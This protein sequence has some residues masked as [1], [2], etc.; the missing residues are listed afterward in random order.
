MKK[1]Q[2]KTESKRILDLMINSIYTN[3]EIFLRE[4]ISNSSDAMDKLY[5]IVSAEGGKGI[6]RGDF[7][8]V[9]EIDKDSR[10]LIISDNGIGMTREELENNLGTIARSGTMDFRNSNKAELEQTGDK[11]DISDEDEVVDIE[12]DSYRD[13]DIIGQFGVGFYSAFMVSKHISVVSRA[14]GSEEAY[15]WESSGA[16]GYTIDEDIRY[17]HGTTI[18]LILKD[19]TADEDFSRFLEQYTIRTIVKKYSD[20]IRYPIKMEVIKSRQ[21]DESED[22]NPEYEDYTE[23]DTLNSMV[24]LWRRNKNELEDDDYQQFYTDKFHDYEAPLAYSH[25]NA[26]GL[27]SFSGIIYIPAH[28]PYNYYSKE[29]EKGLQLYANGVLIMD[30]CADLLPD[31]FSFVRGLIDSPDLSLNISREILQQSSQL[32]LIAKNL[33]RRI[34][35]ELLSLQENDR[36]KYEE[37]FKDFGLQLKFGIYNSFGMDTEKLQDLLLYHS[38]KEDKLITLAEYI[39]SMPENQNAIYY[40]CG[41]SVSRIRQLPQAELVLDNGFDILALTDDV[42]EFAIKMIREYKEKEI[43]S[44]SDSDIDLKTDIEKEVTKEQA[45]IHKK[46]FASLKDALGDKVKE[47]RLSN[48]LKS[49]PVCI[50]SDGPLSLEMEKVLNSMPVEQQVKADRILEINGSHPVFQTLI[51]LADD[52]KLKIYAT[53][54]YNQALLIE[55]LPIEDPVSFANDI[56]DLMV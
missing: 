17:T 7:E 31:Y 49:H 53:L 48:R 47:V 38:L 34:K 24:P 15:L 42:D 30:K 25:F 44:I 23:V 4:L 16:D 45:K 46:L 26:E 13:I 21:K 12:G 1:K 55:G 8:I 33:D 18:T 40:A 29:F 37:F 54:L 6:D 27:V 28:A 22:E 14:Y 35:N 51:N 9:I 19:D 11:P 43:K 32:Q 36:D 10:T 2:F 52:E 39:E 41:G 5:F 50:T 3:K 56:C 20:Y